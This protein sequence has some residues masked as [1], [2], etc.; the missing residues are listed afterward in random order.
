MCRILNV[1]GMEPRILLGLGHF[2][3]DYVENSRK[4]RPTGKNFGAFSPRYSWN[5]ILNRKFNPKMDTFKAFLSKIRT[6][7]S[8]FKKGMGS[9]PSLP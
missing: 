7:F 4:R 9:L 3:K 8:I 1:V 5:V 6:L 2:D